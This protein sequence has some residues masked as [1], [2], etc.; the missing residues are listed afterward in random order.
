MESLSETVKLSRPIRMNITIRTLTKFF[1]WC[2]IINGGRLIISVV[3]LMGAKDLIYQ[4]HIIFFPISRESHTVMMYQ[5]LGLWKILIILL[6]A[7]PYLALLII[8]S[9]QQ[10]KK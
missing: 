8:G 4:F 3:I 9:K 6:N 10:Q 2:T 1:M 5:L 7:V